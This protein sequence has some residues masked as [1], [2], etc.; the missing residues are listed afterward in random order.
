MSGRSRQEVVRDIATRIDSLRLEH[1]T[2]VGIDGVDAAGKTT[3]ADELANLLQKSGRTVIRASIDGFHNP[4]AIRRQRGPESPEGYFL[5]SFN[6]SVLRA[7]LLDP[8]G[9][10]GSRRFR[11]AVFD[12]R[13]DTEVET[14]IEEAAINSILLFDGAFLLRAE[15]PPRVEDHPSV[16]LLSAEG[17]SESG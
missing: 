11:R 14:P 10:A 2:R 8:L 5:D 1:P 7:I 9:P 4:R 12:F 16:P 6:Y 3:L 13:T 17:W 15:I